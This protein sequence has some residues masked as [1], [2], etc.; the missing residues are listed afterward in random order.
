[1]MSSW[2]TGGAGDD[3]HAC[4]GKCA[5]LIVAVLLGVF[6]SAAGAQSVRVPGQPWTLAVPAGWRVASDRQL[7]AFNTSTHTASGGRSKRAQVMLVRAD[8]EGVFVTIMGEPYG[9][10]MPTLDAL[11]GQFAEQGQKVAPG[12]GLSEVSF[13]RDGAMGTVVVRMDAVTGAMGGGARVS[14]TM[15]RFGKDALVSIAGVAPAGSFDAVRPAFTSIARSVT[16]DAGREHPEVRAAAGAG[17]AGTSAAA[18][19]TSV[20]AAG[21]GAVAAGTGS[22]AAGTGAAGGEPRSMLAVGAGLGV[23]VTMLG[24]AVVLAVRLRSGRREGTPG[25]NGAGSAAAMD[26]PAN[27]PTESTPGAEQ[28]RA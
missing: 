18:A 3:G 4:R 28:D 10:A 15:L 6:A 22:A 26:A 21:T 23:G 20:G 13:D 24:V 16:F 9:E 11:A 14:A 1:M 27:R 8:N 2:I 7:E 12:L 25:A 5:V 19:G 17:V